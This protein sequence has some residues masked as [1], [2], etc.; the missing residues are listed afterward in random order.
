MNINIIDDVEAVAT[1][2][3]IVSADLEVQ[4]S[5]LSI[6][7]GLACLTCLLNFEVLSQKL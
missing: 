4:L 1:T 3:K 5:R 6:F 2:D 7:L